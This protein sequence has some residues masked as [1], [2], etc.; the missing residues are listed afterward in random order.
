MRQY[1]GVVIFW[2]YCYEVSGNRI[3]LDA[4]WGMVQIGAWCGLGH[5]AAMVQIG[6]VCSLGHGVHKEGNDTDWG[7]VRIKESCGLGNGAE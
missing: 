1:T 3:S 4:G 5:G 7:L 6:E 2:G